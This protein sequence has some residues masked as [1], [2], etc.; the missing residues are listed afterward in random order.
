[1][2]DFEPTLGYLIVAARQ[3]IRH[4]ICARAR[5]Y[6]LTSQQ[7]WAIVAL[8]V[9]PGATPG[10]L[11]RLLLLDPPGA[12][13][14]VAALSRRKLVELRPD[15]EDRR[16]MRAFLTDAGAQLGEK[17]AVIADDFRAALDGGISRDEEAALRTALRRVIEGLAAFEAGRTSAAARRAG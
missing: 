14:L 6:R 13:R 12:S 16:R 8:R 9:Y 15:R 5:R 2:Q 17:L 4:A 10:E 3:S 11:A 7:F 1:V